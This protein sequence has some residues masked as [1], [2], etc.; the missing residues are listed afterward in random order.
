MWFA[1]RPVRAAARKRRYLGTARD[2]MQISPDGVGFPDLDRGGWIVVPWPAIN[3][4]K[5]MTWRTVRFLHLE[6]S[7]DLHA[8]PARCAGAGRPGGAA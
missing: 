4:A 3:G 5:I 2:A 8:G 7:P 6:L 1:F